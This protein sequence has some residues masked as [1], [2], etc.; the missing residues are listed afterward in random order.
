MKNVRTVSSVFAGVTCMA[1]AAVAGAQTSITLWDF[2]QAGLSTTSPAPASG[3]GTATLIG[4]AQPAASGAFASQSGSS[5][6]NAGSAWN[7]DRYPAQGAASGTGGVEFQANCTGFT[8]VSFEYDFRCSNSFSNFVD[9]LHSTDGGTTWTSFLTSP[10]QIPSANFVTNFGSGAFPGDPILT[11][12][13]AADNNP[14]VR[15][16]IV[17]VFSPNTPGQYEANTTGSTYG[18]GGTIRLDMVEFKG[19]TSASLAP[20]ITANTPIIPRGVCAGDS[21]TQLLLQVNVA[22]GQ[23]PASTTLNVTADLTSVGGSNNTSLIDL[24]GGA[25]GVN[26]TMG[27]S[28]TP[29][30]KTIPVSVVDDQN[31]TDSVNLTVGV[32]NCSNDAASDVVIAQVYGGGG[33]TLSSPPSKQDYVVLYNRSCDPV[34]VS[35]WSIQYGSA[36]GGSGLSLKLDLIPVSSNYI[37]PAKSYFLVQT[38]VAGV[39]DLGPDL[40]TLKTPDF[41]AAGNPGSGLNMSNT[42]GRVALV[43]DGVLIG[44]DLASTMIADYVGYGTTAVSFEGAAP[45]VTLDSASALFRKTG[46]NQ[47]SNENFNDF[48]TFVA[49]PVNSADPVGG[50]CTPACPADLDNGSATGT[51]DGGVDINDLLYFLAQFELGNMDLDNDGVD[52]QQPDGGTDIN[53]LLFFLFH[54]EA[55]C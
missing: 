43:K 20:D 33:A 21:T 4:N 44:N 7:T 17:T 25:Y 12:P 53:D 23:N 14:D 8:G 46:G 5:D 28:I 40:S 37:I 11:L 47:D 2:N 3:V 26:F 32:G 19:T 16:R 45:T 18:T 42:S 13:A 49:A 55:G 27:G 39:A 52:P 24:G 10:F 22:P 30:A 54:F 31:R 38:N 1:L 9:I 48:E 29:G 36:A 50:T 6:L 51:P 35:N 41:A 34:D 15:V